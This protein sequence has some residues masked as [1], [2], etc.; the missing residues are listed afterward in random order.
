MDWSTDMSVYLDNPQGD[1]DISLLSG[2]EC[3]HSELDDALGWQQ[4]GINDDADVLLHDFG[5]PIAVLPK[6]TPS[7]S[8]DI[9]SISSNSNDTHRHPCLADESVAH[10]SVPSEI[11]YKTVSSSASQTD[12]SSLGEDDVL[13]P[14]YPKF[15]LMWFVSHGTLASGISSL[16]QSIPTLKRLAR[17]A[18]MAWRD[19]TG[20]SSES[21]GLLTQEGPASDIVY[22]TQASIPASI[23]STYAT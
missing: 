7:S 10:R 22:G 21:T 20:S 19:A 17:N 4:E 8:S 2:I 13:S 18:M 3:R 14:I 23:R 16:G 11:R 9:S 1:Q 12:I 6:R 15:Y 5:L